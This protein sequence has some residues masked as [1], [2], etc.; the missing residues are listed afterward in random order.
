MSTYD[1]RFVR[2]WSQARV[3]KAEPRPPPGY[4]LAVPPRFVLINVV[5]AAL[6][7]GNVPR[8]NIELR[9]IL[10]IDEILVYYLK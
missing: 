9:R 5:G 2:A 1:G 3:N 7:G 8:R 6:G 4:F 10:M